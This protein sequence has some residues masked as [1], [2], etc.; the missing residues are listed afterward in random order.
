MELNH[1]PKLSKIQ[2]IMTCHNPV[3]GYEEMDQM[4]SQRQVSVGEVMVKNT[5]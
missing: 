1:V 4:V 5:E 2:F 3:P